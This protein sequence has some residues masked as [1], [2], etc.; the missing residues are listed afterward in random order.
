MD[1]T[2]FLFEVWEVS[3]HDFFNFRWLKDVDERNSRNKIYNWKFIILL[4][5]MAGIYLLVLKRGMMN[6]LPNE[7]ANPDYW[8]SWKTR[9]TNRD[10]WKNSCRTVLFSKQY[11]R[12][13]GWLLSQGRCCQTSFKR[14]SIPS[15]GP[16]FY[17]FWRLATL[18]GSVSTV[19]TIR[20]AT[21]VKRSYG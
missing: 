6:N 7:G 20:K 9:I 17:C 2:R 21:T 11:S 4:E 12:C 1:G 14:G 8:K 3:S 16:L 5:T 15:W 19:S 18:P 13:A 10:I